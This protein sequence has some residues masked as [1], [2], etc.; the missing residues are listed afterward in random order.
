MQ[1]KLKYFIMDFKTEKEFADFWLDIYKCLLGKYGAYCPDLFDHYLYKHGKKVRRKNPHFQLVITID[2][3]HKKKFKISDK[4]LNNFTENC[5]EEGRKMDF[6]DKDDKLKGSCNMG[7]FLTY[8][9]ETEIVK[10]M[11]RTFDEEK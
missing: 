11:R 3:K 8:V 6:L 1:K 5:L 4:I 2:D 10:I 9:V 7:H